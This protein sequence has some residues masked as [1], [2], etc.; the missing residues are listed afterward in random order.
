MTAARRFL[1][2][3]GV[4]GAALAWALHLVVG[5]WLEEAACST[6][7][8][9]WFSGDHPAQIGTTAVALAVG[10]LALLAAAV[11]FRSVRRG[12]VADPRGRVFFLA[13]AGIGVSAFF[14]AITAIAGSGAIILDPC[15]PG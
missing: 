2:W 15:T 14:L 9:R 4:F 13:A 10:V 12:E 5:Y 3:F 8:S 11:S 6:G 7:S 1:L